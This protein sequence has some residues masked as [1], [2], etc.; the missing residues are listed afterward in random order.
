MNCSI[1]SI[2]ILENLNYNRANVNT[3]QNYLFY[4]RTANT[5]RNS[6]LFR[7]MT[8]YNSTLHNCDM[9]FLDEHG[10]KIN[11]VREVEPRSLPYPICGRLFK[12]MYNYITKL[13]VHI[14]HN[15]INFH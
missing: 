5:S 8:E 14:F 3:R 2:F 13:F 15:T 11:K 9:F 7:M 4:T 12:F 1:D 10:F 6:P